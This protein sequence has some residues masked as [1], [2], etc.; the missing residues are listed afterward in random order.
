MYVTVARAYPG[1]SLSS[2]MLWYG[3]LKSSGGGL[4]SLRR[5]SSKDLASL[6]LIW[7]NPR[8]AFSAVVVVANIY[9]F[10]FVAIIF[11]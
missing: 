7:L 1:V 3:M 5:V 4:Q 8:G 2:T 11:S 10:Y 6:D 9:V